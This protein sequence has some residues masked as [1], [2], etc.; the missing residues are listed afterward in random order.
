MDVCWCAWDTPAGPQLVSGAL[1][2]LFGPPLH[3]SNCNILNAR[4][5]TLRALQGKGIIG[6]VT[7]DRLTRTIG[8]IT[9][10]DLRLTC[11]VKDLWR[12]GW[13]GGGVRLCV[14]EEE[15]VSQHWKLHQRSLIHAK[16]FHSLGYG[17]ICLHQHL[18]VLP[19][20]VLQTQQCKHRAMHSVNTNMWVYVEWTVMC[21]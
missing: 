5:H 13:M 1:C 12:Y 19:Q 4:T 17:K 11:S 3:F 2:T 7:S 20:H 8:T 16:S 21:Q 10:K 15:G 14:N 18:L 9:L 6:A